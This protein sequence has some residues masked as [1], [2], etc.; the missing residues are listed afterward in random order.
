MNDYSGPENRK[1]RFIKEIST[2]NIASIITMIA[3]AISITM[4]VGD[5]DAKVR[6]NTQEIVAMKDN[7]NTIQ[8]ERLEF[9]SNLNRRLERIEDKMDRLLMLTSKDSK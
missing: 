5:I 2:G 9:R 1:L 7:I 6:V 4:Y 8:V 3:T